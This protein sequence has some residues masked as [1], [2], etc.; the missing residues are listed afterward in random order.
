LIE[1]YR[2]NLALFSVF[3]KGICALCK[4]RARRNPSH[5]KI[6]VRNRIALPWQLPF[7]GCLFL[8]TQFCRK[9][10]VTFFLIMSL[11]AVSSGLQVRNWLVRE[12]PA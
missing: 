1:V 6:Y 5:F 12:Q 10:K 9:Y 8:L 7:A 11:I 2:S 3:F 4:N